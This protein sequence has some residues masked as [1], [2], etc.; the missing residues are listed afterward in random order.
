MAWTGQDLALYDKFL[1]EWYMA[2]ARLLDYPSC[3]C[4]PAWFCHG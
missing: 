4:N 3:W 2:E 1:K